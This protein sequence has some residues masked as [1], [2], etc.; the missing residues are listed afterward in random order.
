MTGH[1][2]ANGIGHCDAKITRS[3]SGTDVRSNSNLASGLK[4]IRVKSC[5]LPHPVAR[6]DKD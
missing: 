3:K 6:L 4:K 1:S 2:L 5:L